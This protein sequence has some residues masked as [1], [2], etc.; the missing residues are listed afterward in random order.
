ML[1]LQGTMCSQEAIIARLER[2]L[3]KGSTEKRALEVAAQRHEQQLAE[4][5]DRVD[6]ARLEVR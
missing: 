2:L 3:K 6:G 1:H 4:A 5:Q